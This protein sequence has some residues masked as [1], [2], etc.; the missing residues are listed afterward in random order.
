MALGWTQ[1][2]INISTRNIPGR[3][4]LQCVRVTT[5]PL[6]NWVSPSSKSVAKAHRYG[7][8]LVEAAVSFE[9]DNRQILSHM[10]GL[11]ID[12]PNG[13]TPNAHVTDT[14]VPAGDRPN[15]SPTFIT[16]LSDAILSWPGCG[17]LALA[18]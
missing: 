10:S 17:R 1:N 13:T 11:L 15:N 2:L 3:K 6:M 16:G 5:S 4:G 8:R 14:C 12:K 9:T 7:F 18:F